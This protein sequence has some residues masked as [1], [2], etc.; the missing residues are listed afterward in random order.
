MRLVADQRQG[1]EAAR[2]LLLQPLVPGVD[3]KLGEMAGEAADRRRVGAAVVVEDHN[4]VRGLAHR[5][6][7]QGLVGHA[8]GKCAVADDGD[9]VTWFSALQPS[10][11]DT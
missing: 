1:G 6:L 11:G 5:D 4:Q 7:V 10:F 2:D 3:L 8:A 9:D